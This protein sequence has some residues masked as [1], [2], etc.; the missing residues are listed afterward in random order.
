VGA[1]E[2]AR[3]LGGI[4]AMRL[5]PTRINGAPALVLRVDGEVNAVIAMRVEDGLIMGLYA[6]R[7]PEKLT[8]VGTE[9][10]V[11]R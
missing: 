3:V 6:V 1:A 2:V 10:P 11:S 8:R 9:T 4:A 5:E 7:N